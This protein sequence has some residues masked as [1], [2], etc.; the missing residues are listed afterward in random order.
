MPDMNGL[1]LYNSLNAI[2]E[3]KVNFVTALDIAQEHI[4][5]LPSL[6]EKML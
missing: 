5:T 4:S 2:P 6:K 3:S 1:Q